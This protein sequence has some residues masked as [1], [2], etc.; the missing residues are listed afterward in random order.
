MKVSITTL[1]EDS[2]GENR[3]LNAE[4]GLSFYIEAGE[5][6]FLFDTGSTNL[7]L[8]NAET[9]GLHPET[10]KSVIISHGH[11]DHS[12][13]YTAFLECTGG[14]ETHLFVRPGF[15][16]GKYGFK[17]GGMAFLGNPF[18]KGEIEQAG[19][20]IHEIEEEVSEIRPGVYSVTGFERNTPLETVNP[21]FVV[22]RN[23]ER[24]VD[25]FSDEQI[26]V[27]KTTQGL[28]V[29]LGCSHPGMINI[30]EKVKTVFKE[31]IHAVIGGT[32]RVEADAKRIQVTTDYLLKEKIPHV[33]ICHC[34][35]TPDHLKELISQLGDAYRPIHTG[36]VVS[37]Q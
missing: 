7:F 25:T 28:V 14:Q 16:D 17:A 33:M 35:G 26:L 22:D 15:F 29:V 20:V 24:Q 27:M 32:H 10:F 8:K 11:Y 4:H 1:V 37:F 9:L 21:R 36:S 12:G 19:V 18:S 13:G 34:S 2:L 3:Q 23:G 5:E 31:P 6:S 30:L